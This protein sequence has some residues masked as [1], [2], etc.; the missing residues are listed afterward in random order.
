MFAVSTDH[1][2]R[3]YTYEAAKRLYESV[4]PI[5][6]REHVRPIGKRS[7]DNM[8]IDKAYEE[9][10]D[11]Y[12]AVLYQTPCVTWFPDGRIKVDHGRWA[13]LSTAGFIDAVLGGHNTCMQ[14]NFINVQAKMSDGEVGWF[15]VPDKGLWLMDGV[16]LNPPTMYVEGY[17]RKETSRIREIAAPVFQYFRDM[18]AVIGDVKESF[19]DCDARREAITYLKNRG[20]SVYDYRT[21]LT[22]LR[23]VMGMLNHDKQLSDEMMSAL[24]WFYAGDLSAVAVYSAAEHSGVTTRDVLLV[25]KYLPFGVIKRGMQMETTT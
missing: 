17:N 8:L 20:C 6:G 14:H 25:R 7:K 9:G 12:Q 19:W 15:P 21:G 16:V 24:F 13:T 5:R 1:V 11:V 4:K 18:K 2:P 23:V 10:T 3:L 22:P